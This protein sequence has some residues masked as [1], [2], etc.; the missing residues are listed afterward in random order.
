MG[1]GEGLL[2]SP[3]EPWEKEKATRASS[4]EEAAWAATPIAVSAQQQ[5]VGMDSEPLTYEVPVDNKNEVF[6]KRLLAAFEVE[7][8]EHIRAMSSGLIALENAPV[9]EQ[10]LEIIEAIFREAHSL[11]G[12]ARAVNL[13]EIEAICQALESIFAALTRQEM[14]VSTELCDVLHQALDSLG[15][16]LVATEAGLTAAEKSRVGTLVQRLGGLPQV[17][18]GGAQ[19]SE[20]RDQALSLNPA[21]PSLVPISPSPALLDTVRIST[22]KLDALL[23]QAEE[24]LSAKLTASQRAAEL[25]ELSTTLTAWHTERAKIHPAVSAMQ[26]SLASADKRHD[27]ARPS[28]R[29]EHSTAWMRQLLEFLAYHDGSLKALDGKLATL[30]KAAEQD[31]RGLSRMVNDLLVEMKK[32]SMLPF[33]SLLEIVPKLVRDLARDGGKEVEVVIRGGDIEIDR[34]ILEEMKDPLIQVVRNCIDHGIEVPQE[35]ER[36]HKPRHGTMTIAIAQQ[37]GSKVELLIADDG[38][39]IDVARVRFAAQKLGLITPA[40]ADTLDEAEALALVFHSGVSTSPMITDISGRG[41]GLAIVRE[42]V[43]KLGGSVALDTAPDVGT[44]FR[45]A[46]PLT[47][48]TFRGVLVRVAEHL[49]VLPT[50]YVERVLRVHRADIK[51]VENRETLQLDAQVVSLVRL[52]EVLEWSSP[53]LRGAAVDSQPAVV[54]AAAEQRMAFLVDAVLNEQEVLVKRLGPQLL[55]V[56]NIVGATILGTGQVVPVL[57][58]LDVLKSA[59]QA[60]AA[61]VRSPDA[62]ME[63]EAAP[64]KC[65]LVVEDS[66]T[67]R[68]LLTDLLEAAGYQVKTAVDGVD[69][70]A[71][72]RGGG[73]DL[74]VSDVDMPRMNG[75]DLTMK[76]R[77]DKQCAEVPVVL[78]TA[79]ASHADRERGIEVGANAYLVKSSFDQSALLEVIRRLV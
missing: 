50:A 65:V 74:V 27:R 9:M 64:R 10:R 34:R 69:G 41:L 4:I 62:P 52:A 73:V 22:A 7:A 43:E 16:L 33:A 37:N 44:T 59:V 14:A 42:K 31:Q 71:Q 8:R 55:R 79:L 60:S 24:L 57:N 32:V 20:V 51:T 29:L 30:A 25:R 54:L 63:P 67:A 75:F 48:A 58:V 38:M 46:L 45:M 6:L 72:L 49:Y 53:R 21:P 66:I 77:G 15:T 12:A 36:K 28:A 70:L 68:M 5:L 23:L 2:T 40:E 17:V 19:E 56:R 18:I 3:R 1:W 35:R 61:A 78:V 26:Q 11:K 76:I 13:A 47:I 39:G